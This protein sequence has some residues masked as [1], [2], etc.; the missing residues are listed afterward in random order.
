MKNSEILENLSENFYH[1][2]KD[3]IDSINFQLMLNN[4]ETLHNV[5]LTKQN[6]T[7]HKRFTNEVKELERI[8]K[9]LADFAKAECSLNFLLTFDDL[10]FVEVTLDWDGNLGITYTG[11]HY[12]LMVGHSKFG[13]Q[14]VKD[15]SDWEK[16]IS[17]IASDDYGFQS[18]KDIQWEALKSKVA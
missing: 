15:Y 14:F 3:I 7:K 1:Q 6:C 4:S 18:D 10:Y 16:A 9:K 2:L 5:S 13:K 8:S 17:G 11:C 12:D